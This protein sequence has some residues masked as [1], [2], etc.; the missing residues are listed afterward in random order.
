[1]VPH[2]VRSLMAAMS[3]VVLLVAT[4]GLASAQYMFLDVDGDGQNSY[5]FERSQDD[6]VHA[7]LYIVTDKNRNGSDATCETDGAPLELNGFTAVFEDFY[8]PFE[9][10]SVQPQIPGMAQTFAPVVTPYG[11][12]VGYST[13]PLPPGKHLVLRMNVLSRGLMILPTSC[14]APPGVG[15]TIVTSCAGPADDY[16]MGVEGI[17]YGYATDPP[18]RRSITTA[19]PS[20][21]VTEGEPLS[22]TVNV[23][24]PECGGYPF[25]FGVSGLPSGASFSGLGPFGYQGASGTFSWT[26]TIG[27]AGE[28]DV[29]FATRDPD[30][31]NMTDNDQ[32]HT[33]HITVSP[34][35]PL[36]ANQAPVARA[37]GPYS[38]I[39]GSPVTFEAGGSSDPDGDGLAFAWDFGDGEHG[40]G[41][42]A[43]HV[44]GAAGEYLVVLTASDVRG[45]V[46]QDN[47]VATI[48]SGGLSL[49]RSIAPN[50]VRANSVLEIVTSRVGVVTTRLFD[51]RGRLLAQ[52]AQLLGAGMHR[53]PIPRSARDM[54]SGIYIVQVNDELQ[55]T[56]TRRIAFIH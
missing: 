13:P 4:A 41:I 10:I 45:A 33:T 47:V 56:E 53:I 50:P 15:T 28:Y 17:G 52:S 6:T 26:P 35:V 14:I 54:P 24:D 44:Y 46:S 9:T 23:F 1:M 37:G 34:A 18:N 48:V 3:S 5:W 7:D 55:R 36:A 51:V 42:Q 32:V 11:L 29:V 49:I 2:P 20:V 40:A 8:Q 25:S 31:F 43:S 27:Q 21:A 22:F 19:P 30:P 16:T 39:V 38:A 12:S